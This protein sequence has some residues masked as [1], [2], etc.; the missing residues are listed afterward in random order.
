VRV[1]RKLAWVEAKLL[2]RE[3]L[4]LVFSFVFPLVTL[5]V[6]AEVFGNST[7]GRDEPTFRNVGAIDYYVPAYVA[8]VIAAIGLVSLPVHLASY[9]ER[10]VLRRLRASELKPRSL[11][12]AHVLVGLVLG[13]LT[14]FVMSAAAYAVYGN[15]LPVSWLGVI[16]GFALVSVTFTAIGVTLGSLLPN[17]RSAQVAG[18]ILFF[19]MMM[20]CGAGPPPEVISGPMQIVADGL[21]LTY[22]IRLIQDPWLGFGWSLEAILAT[23]G[24]LLVSGAL[25]L[26]PSIGGRKPARAVEPSKGD[27]SSVRGVGHGPARDCTP[28]GGQSDR[29]G[30]EAGRSHA[31]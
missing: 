10:G 15:A 25:V 31:G 27:E 16:A 8:L 18:M 28:R 20:L 22:G 13:G 19:V 2:T 9:R 24:F 5:F 26:R 4:T 30:A 12:G 23:V 11:F 7:A 14:T 3:P 21:P 29:N 6:M 1:A 17:A